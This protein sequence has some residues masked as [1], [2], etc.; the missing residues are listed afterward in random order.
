M[1][2]LGTDLGLS[3]GLS[4][5]LRRAGQAGSP[6]R[7]LGSLA[8]LRPRDLKLHLPTASE[9]TTGMTMGEHAEIMAREWDVARSDQDRLA[10]DSHR[11]AVQ[12]VEKGFFRDLLVGPGTFAA[13]GDALPRP[14]TSLDR[15]AALPP[16]FDREAGTLTAGNSTPLTDGAA[17]VW[18]ASGEGADLLPA[19]LPRVRMLDWD[20][21]AIDPDSEGLLMAPALAV[22]RLLARHGLA[23]EDVELWEIHEAFAAQ[24][25]C[26]YAAL[27]DRDWLRERAGVTADLGRFTRDRVNPNGGS[28]ALGHPFGATGARILSQAASELA[29][30]R[31]GTRGVV[32]ICAAGGLGHVALLEAV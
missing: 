24:V 5:S 27:E 21:A 18:V 12:A 20:Q 3:P 28:V 8:E 17:A 22:P 11:K 26:T 7:A 2:C 10:L 4:R 23:Y 29:D 14:D 15:L 30:R 19:E 6:L 16:S 31:A 1:L 32:S 9:R 13:D 25:L